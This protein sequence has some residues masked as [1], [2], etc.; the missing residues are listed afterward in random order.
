MPRN[1]WTHSSRK[2]EYA[3]CAGW[4]EQNDTIAHVDVTE[5][6]LEQLQ[7]LVQQGRLAPLYTEAN[8]GYKAALQTL[9]DNAPVCFITCDKCFA[10]TR[11]S[12]VK[13]LRSTAAFNYWRKRV[14]LTK[15]N[16]QN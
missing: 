1:T 15:A 3:T 14:K 10:K 6:A 2:A 16:Q 5:T 9:K 4:V 8:D 13:R 11:T 7:E 12:C